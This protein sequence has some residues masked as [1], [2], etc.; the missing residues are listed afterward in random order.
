MEYFL[1]RKISPNIRGKKKGTEMVAPHDYRP[2]LQ[3]PEKG[4]YYMA[5]SSINSTILAEI[6]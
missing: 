2:K 6:L 3:E 4:C 5:R 1:S